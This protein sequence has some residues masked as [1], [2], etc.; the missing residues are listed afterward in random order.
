MKT[1]ITLYC[2]IILCGALSIFAGMDDA[3]LKEKLTDRLLMLLTE[4]N[5]SSRKTGVPDEH[6]HSELKEV[7]DEQFHRV[8]M[9]LYKEAESKWTTLTPNTEEWAKNKQDVIGVLACLSKC[10]DIPVKDFLLDYVASK[11]KENFTRTVAL[12]S[13]LRVADAEEAKDVLLRFLIGGERMDDYARSSIYVHAKDV[14]DVSSPDKKAAILHAFCEAAAF[15]SPQWVFEECDIR[16]LL[17]DPA[18]RESP[19]RESMLRRQLSLPFSKYYT[20]LETQM[21]K[22]IERIEKIKQHSVISTNLASLAV[23]NVNLTPSGF[24]TNSEAGAIPAD[25]VTDPVTADAA[26]R[27]PGRHVL[28]GALALLLLGF[29][30]WRFMRK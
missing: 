4:E 9:E 27:G 19:R 10:G 5:F 1:H 23:Q 18:W 2:S 17:M 11:E 16:L 30:A 8:L 29:G 12:S 24:L 6:Y 22:E 26:G 28:F 3:R 13:Y 25:P 7:S 20:E 14:W 15:E 21:E